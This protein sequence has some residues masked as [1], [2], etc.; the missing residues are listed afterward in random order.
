MN[1][2]LGIIVGVA[3]TAL[4]GGTLF[5]G[6]FKEKP[7]EAKSE[8]TIIVKDR[9]GNIEVPKNPE[10]VIVLGYSSLDN[11]EIL[12]EEAIALPKASLPDYLE[13][14][15]DDKYIDL[16]SIKKFDIEQI[17]ELKPELI[18]IENR[19][20][21][22]Y[23]E[24]SKIAPTIML[25]RDGVDHF[26]TLKN[27]LDILGEIFEKEEIADTY[28]ADIQNRT[29]QIKEN[30]TKINKNALITMVYDG[31]ITAFG[32]DSR[33]GMIHNEFGFKES[34]NNIA[35]ESH[36]QTVNSEYV[37]NKNPE[38]LFVIDKTMLASKPQ[39]SAK[40]ILQNELIQ[41][42]AAYKNEN[43]VYLDTKAWYLGGP[44][45]LATQK[46]LSDIENIIRK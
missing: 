10:K 28:L 11:M 39:K 2:K 32:K 45:V 1:K 29:T 44:G 46:M 42:T 24:L 22:Y 15:K 20:E 3:I 35:T 41:K 8:E 25:G 18:I 7:T 6:N 23:D 14:Y 4:V 30:V 5:F 17:Y 12:E 26:A 36:G 37:L 43:I 31:E 40:E 34:D 38:Y 21:E 33:F 19:Q 13:K 27:D 9:K 16:G